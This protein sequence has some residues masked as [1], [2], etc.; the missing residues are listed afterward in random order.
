MS[1]STLWKGLLAQHSP[2]K[3][4]FWGVN[5]IQFT[6]FW[7]A[8]AVYTALPY[9]FP[10]FSARHKLQKYEKQPTPEEIWKC[11]RVVFRNQ[12]L[13][14]ALQLS[15]I[16]LDAYTGR[17]PT[18][19]FDPILPSLTEVVRD[20]ILCI[21]IREVIAYYLHRLFHHPLLYKTMHKPHHAFSPPVALAAQYST[22]RE[23]V[24]LGIMP[25]AMP[26][27]FLK[28]H[29]V[30]F[31]VFLAL[32]LLETSTM[33]SGYDFFAS[34]ARRHDLHHEKFNVC[35][36]P[37]GLMD[38]VHGTEWKNRADIKGMEVQ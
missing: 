4:A 20:V 23:H 9:I 30:T 2:A 21:L 34:F 36:G 10:A 17:P 32:Q 14:S 28:S 19:R 12:V 1:A 37:T 24:I 15:I 5:T 29:V 3:I 31:W 27:A 11:F 26:P 6:C 8:S 33:H 7:F 13:S 16:A 25:I 35:F 18:H 38:W 22:F